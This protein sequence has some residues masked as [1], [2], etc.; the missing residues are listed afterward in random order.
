MS[1]SQEQEPREAACDSRPFIGIT[2]EEWPGRLTTWSFAQSARQ[3]SDPAVAE[4]RRMR[5][6]ESPATKAGAR[7]G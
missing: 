3:F 4:L 5:L 2:C 7:V 1:T 6:W